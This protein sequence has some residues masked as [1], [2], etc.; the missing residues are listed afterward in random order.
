MKNIRAL[1]GAAVLADRTGASPSLDLKKFNLI[2]GFNGSGKSTLSR[3]LASLEHGKQQAGLPEACS[4]EIELADG[5]RYS[6]QANLTGLEERVRV[7]NKDFIAANLRW[8]TGQASPV[9]Y[10]GVDQTDSAAK[11]KP[12][13]DALPTALA[14]AEGERNVA[15]ERE[16]AFAEFKKLVARN[17][18]GRL[19]QPSRYEAP[20]FIAD[21][22]K[23]GPADTDKLNNAELDAAT[24]TCARSNPPAKVMAVG[25]PVSGF[26]NT[27]DSALNLAPKTIG[28][29]MVEDLAKN[30]QMVP[31]AKQ[32]HEYH[33][34]HDLA[35]CLY[36]AN[37][38]SPERRQALT[39]AFDD[40]F[41]HFVTEVRTAAHHALQSLEAVNIV[42][43]NVP[44]A[45]ELSA[46]FE[47]PYKAAAKKLDAAFEDINPL[48]AEA[49]RALNA[50]LASP[51][52][53]IS[54]E[55]PPV[56][57]IQER[58]MALER[59]GEELNEIC[60]QHSDLV[61]NF[62][63][64]Q[65]R[66]RDAIRRHF[67]IESSQAFKNHV[68]IIA[69][70]H[71]AERVTREH[72]HELESELADLRSKIRQHGP[73]AEKINALVASYLGH[74]ELS[75]V[76]VGEGYE[77]HRHGSL[78]KG[79]PSEGEKTAIAICYFLSSLEAED[80]KL[81]D[82][83]VVV[84]DPV[85]SLD[86]KAMNYACS[87][88]RNRLSGASQVIVLTHNHHCMNELKKAWKGASRGDQPAAT[89]KFID[90]RIPSD[91]GLRT[92][93]IIRLPNHLRDYD[94][95]Y[96]FLFEKVITFSAAGDIHYDYTFMMPNVL[97]RVLEIFLAFKTPRDGNISD[98][99]GTL[100]KRNSDLDP[101]RLNALERLSQ[102]ESH[103]DNLDD[104]IS[105]SAMTIEE[106][107]AA[108]AALLD[109]MRTVDPHH[110]ADMRKHCAP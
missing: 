14:V 104:L 83:I 91:T 85:S 18:S 73:A 36:C 44:K 45:A 61:D 106:S 17:V 46:E 21:I 76:A 65:R 28:S 98:K 62:V 94:S 53:A 10:M 13:E 58:F 1:K 67:A 16:K 30:P 54:V 69:S 70:A 80:R 88:I 103:S 41:S 81:K 48:V 93:T 27:I 4:F 109:L 9:F 79:E 19:R 51:T 49:L 68:D 52:A 42:R 23:L 56:Q 31:W 43:N 12:I 57:E 77:L 82:L 87:L 11:I 92:S 63:Q 29:I 33:V 26:L 2:Y 22:E 84:D 6:S 86:T 15:E 35:T 110:L 37:V 50:R 90:V 66:A 24:A 39:D 107:Q 59:A 20:Q 108:C 71:E 96:H 74:N 99:L 95:E 102:I 8:E 47:A 5:L 3:I 89:L 38:I 97:R 34:N 64:H 75:V 72:I 105:Q 32:G 40:S 60:E 101:S 100:C 7:F 78:V 55:L 25:I